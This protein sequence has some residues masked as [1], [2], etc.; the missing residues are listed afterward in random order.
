[1]NLEQYDVIYVFGLPETV[2]KK[3]FPI[4]KNIKNKN[5]RLISY[6]FKMTNNHFKEFKHKPD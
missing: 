2:T 3:V 6:C 4:I 1:M 5:F